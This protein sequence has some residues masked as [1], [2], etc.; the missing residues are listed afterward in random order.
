[1]DGKKFAAL[2]LAHFHERLYYSE[3]TEE[4]LEEIFRS[5][6]EKTYMEKVSRV[7]LLVEMDRQNGRPWSSQKYDDEINNIQS[8]MAEVIKELLKTEL[9]PTESCIDDLE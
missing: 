5:Y 3:L 4:S 7:S 9:E 1:M 2:A 8:D 6:F